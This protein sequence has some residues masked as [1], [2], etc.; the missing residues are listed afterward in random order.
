M[1]LIKQTKDKFGY[2]PTLLKTKTH[3]VVAACDVC[4]TVKEG[5]QCDILKNPRYTCRACCL[6]EQ[7][8]NL[9]SEKV[10]DKRRQTM[11]DR[12]GVS[13]VALIPGVQ[14]KIKASNLR[15]YGVEHISQSKDFQAKKVISNLK[16]FGVEYFV[17]TAAFKEKSKD[18]CIERY[19][20]N[21]AMQS[22]VIQ[23]R[24]KDNLMEYYGVDNLFKSEE[25]KD[26]IKKTNLKK[27]GVEHVAS[28]KQVHDKIIAT[29]ILRYG[30]PNPTQN[31]EI[32]LKAVA[33][34]ERRYGKSSLFSFFGKTQKE[35][36]N[37]LNS[38]G[39]NFKSDRLVLNGFELDMYDKSINFALEY[40]GLYWHSDAAPKPKS[41]SYHYH[42]YKTCKDKGI[43]LITIFE[44]EWLFRNSQVRNFI[45]SAL[46]KNSSI[47]MGRK[48]TV[49]MID[50]AEARKYI[51]MWHIQG[52]TKTIQI[53][54]ALKYDNEIVG[55]MS[56]GRHPRDNKVTVLDRLCFRDDTTVLGGA[57][58]LFSFLLKQ[59]NITSI[60]SW[61]DNRWSAGNI[62]TKLGFKLVKEL[63]PDY[64]YFNNHNGTRVSKQ[65]Q[66]KRNTG[67]PANITEKEWCK[68]KGF[69]RIWDCGKI[70]WE[71]TKEKPKL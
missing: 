51:D 41:N 23:R 69:Y 7:I 71:F 49:A 56:F 58:K 30:F 59:S 65:S 19:G 42:K 70:R 35:I 6:K 32:Y 52:S 27:Y 21:N 8:I 62:Y 20:V 46:G 66:Q 68:S 61:S 55:V 63:K 53:A 1:I 39:F 3:K 40:N 57:S 47:L 26:K 38:L 43:R 24:Y 14:T 33:T 31:R 18:T 12:F 9:A 45:K 13:C 67:C 17:Q 29:N 28:N 2:D 10:K 34:L 54:A 15:K 60:T 36:T 37:W 16:N 5:R 50:N 22:P 4:G 48:C 11:M 64:S 25:I 44:D